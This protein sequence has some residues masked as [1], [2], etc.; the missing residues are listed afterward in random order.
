MAEKPFLVLVLSI[1]FICLGVLG[2]LMSLTYFMVVEEIGLDLILSL[3]IGLGYL[4]IGYDLYKG[5]KWGWILA[6]SLVVINIVGNIYYGYYQA[7]V[8]DAIMIVL[9]ILTASYYG[10][11]YGKPSR[12]RRTSPV[13][14]PSKPIA[15]AFIIPREEKRFV[16][17]KHKY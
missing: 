9:L 14:P 11:P 6:F 16:K 3:V 4:V 12:P 10:I 15:A 5:N 7:L 1:S 17:R 2:I 8:V 13:P